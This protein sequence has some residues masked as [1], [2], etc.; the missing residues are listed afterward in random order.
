MP[1]KTVVHDEWALMTE[2]AQDRLYCIYK[3]V[4]SHNYRCVCVCNPMHV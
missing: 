2:V 3:L 4:D 1:R